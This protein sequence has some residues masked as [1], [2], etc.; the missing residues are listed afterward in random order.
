MTLGAV[1]LLGI[2]GCGGGSRQDKNEPGGTFDVRVVKASFPTAQHIAGQARMRIAVR[3]TGSRTV[4]NLAVTVKGFNR[5]DTTEG[6][7]DPTR[8]I[9]VVDSGPKGA[10]TAYVETWALGKLLPGRT[11]TFE[12]RVTPTRPGHY[13][14]RYEVAAGLNGK[15]KA[16]AE[17]GG[18]PRGRFTVVVSGKAPQSRVNPKTGAVERD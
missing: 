18:A 4:P 1:A 2:T 5:Q 14:L 16:R 15:A 17:S 9:W 11:A 3:N 6:L 13:L 12:W 10:D 8:P 7:A